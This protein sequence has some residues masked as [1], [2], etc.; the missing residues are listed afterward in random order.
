MTSLSNSYDVVLF[1]LSILVTGRSLMSIS[2]LVLELQKLWAPIWAL[3]KIWRLGQVRDRKFETSIS[4]KMLLNAAKCQGYSFY[5]FW[6]ITGKP[7][8]RV[9]SPLGILFCH[10]ELIMIL[11]QDFQLPNIIKMASERKQLYSRSSFSSL[12]R[13][14]LIF[15][16][17]LLGVTIMILV[18]HKDTL[19]KLVCEIC[20][21][22]KKGFCSLS[23][24]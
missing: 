6:V 5:C 10:N 17:W 14:F 8:G 20:D 1:S 13:L 12:A 11:R 2:S 18:S 19:L 22:Q 3:P 16:T 7:R 23:Q 4:N 9:K 15:V 24:I 21:K